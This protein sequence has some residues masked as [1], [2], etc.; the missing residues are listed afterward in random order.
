MPA[1]TL[2]SLTTLILTCACALRAA[3]SMDLAQMGSADME[4]LLE[5]VGD[6]YTGHLAGLD[7]SLGPLQGMLLRMLEAPASGGNGAG[8]AGGGDAGAGGAGTSSDAAQQQQ[9]QQ[10]EGQGDGA[11]GQGQGQE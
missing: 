5:G 9:Q 4:Q 2:R 3:G 7:A 10:H 1:T 6:I 8:A 11:P